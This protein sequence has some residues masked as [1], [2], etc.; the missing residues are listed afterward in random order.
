[1]ERHAIV[2]ID[3]SMSCPA[4]TS[5]VI[6][7]GKALLDFKYEDTEQFFLLDNAKRVKASGCFK[8]IYGSAPSHYNCDEERY[9]SIAWWAMGCLARYT[10]VE[11]FIEDYAFAAKGRVFNIG[12]NTGHLKQLLWSKKIPFHVVAPT[13]VKKLATGKG[14]ADKTVMASAFTE[15]TGIDLADY[16][17]VKP[18]D[19][20]AG[21]LI[22]S[23]FILRHGLTEI[24]NRSA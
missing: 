20:P 15:L 2:G 19:S 1:M 17:G 14:N 24:Q 8:N 12:E 21:D 16:I 23:Y 11:V 7:P 6:K 4:I 22:D 3:Y 9:N 10:S 13:A 5:L 18:G